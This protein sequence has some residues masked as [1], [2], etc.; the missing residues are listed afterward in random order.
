MEHVLPW[1]LPWQKSCYGCYKT[2]WAPGCMHVQIGMKPQVH[3]RGNLKLICGTEHRWCT[4]LLWLDG[5]HASTAPEAAKFQSELIHEDVIQPAIGDREQALLHLFH[6]GRQE[7]ERSLHHP[8][9]AWLPPIHPS[10]NDVL[11]RLLL[12]PSSGGIDWGSSKP[13]MDRSGIDEKEREREKAGGTLPA[14]RARCVFY[15]LRAL[16]PVAGRPS[17]I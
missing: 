1:L 15:V 5:N 7:S 16:L 4:Y 3:G 11:W 10:P 12:R 6:F 2:S 13:W 9:A 8:A 17:S 14:V